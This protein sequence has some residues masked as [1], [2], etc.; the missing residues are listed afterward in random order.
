MTNEEIIFQK[1]LQLMDSGI[2]GTTGRRI[3]IEDEYGEE[4]EVCEPVEV[5]TF[6][7]WESIGYR[8]RRGEHACASFLI[9]RHREAGKKKDKTTGEISETPETMFMTN[10]HFFSETQVEKIPSEKE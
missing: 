8:V 3:T 4:R 2:I 6:T 7:G 5:H 10:A 1:R 9:W